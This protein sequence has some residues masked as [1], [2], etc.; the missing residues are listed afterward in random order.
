MQIHYLEAAVDNYLQV[1]VETSVA[2]HKEDLPGDILIFLTGQ[3]ECEAGKCVGL[4][5][6]CG[7]CLR[8]LA[9]G[10]APRG[11]LP[12]KFVNWEVLRLSHGREVNNETARPCWLRSF[13]CCALATWDGWKAVWAELSNSFRVLPLTKATCRPHAVA[14]LLEEE[15]RRLQRSRL[16]WRLQPMALYA[17]LSAPHQL[18]AFDAAPRGVRKVRLGCVVPVS[19][20]AAGGAVVAAAGAGAVVSA[21]VGA[22]VPV[23]GNQRLGCHPADQRLGAIDPA[24]DR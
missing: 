11:G 4:G 23:P 20:G 18:A 7:K 10:D 5:R 22:V 19:A 6:Q 3:D 13:G 16:K 21:G 1:A 12:C 24:C 14:K 17:G 15:G 9:L 2:I 8:S